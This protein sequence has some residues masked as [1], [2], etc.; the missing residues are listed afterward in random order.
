[1]HFIQLVGDLPVYKLIVQ[2]KNENPLIFPKILPILGPFHCQCS[3]IYVI[4]KRFAGSGLPD[5]IVCADVIAEKSVDEAFRAKHFN[6]II[7]ALQLTYEVLQRKIVRIGVQEA[8]KISHEIQSA[9]ACL[10]H[11]QNQNCKLLPNQ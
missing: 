4:N 10:R 7:R 6:R 3:F 11:P 8:L 1:M 9:L 2:L 5:I